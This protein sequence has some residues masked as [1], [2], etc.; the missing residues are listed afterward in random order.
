[1][2]A[3]VEETRFLAVEVVLTCTLLPIMVMAVIGNIMIIVAV[4]QSWKLRNHVSNVFIVN[5]AITDLGCAGK[6]YLGNLTNFDTLG[7]KL[8][9]LNQHLILPVLNQYLHRC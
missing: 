8:T 9:V 4:T 3:S 5:L 1:M 6:N 2:N 7:V